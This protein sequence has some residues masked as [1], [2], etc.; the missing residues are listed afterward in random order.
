VELLCIGGEQAKTETGSAQGRIIVRTN[1]AA[2]SFDDRLTYSQTHAHSGVFGRKE[3]IEKTR[4]VLGINTRAAV[5]DAA[6]HPLRVREHSSERNY[7][8]RWRN[9]RHRLDRVHG[10]VDDDLLE[11]SAVPDNLGK[12]R[13]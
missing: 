9:L 10:Q 4:E 6:V 12:L 3:A 13:R 1:T 5:L 2:M 11:L 7:A 8:A